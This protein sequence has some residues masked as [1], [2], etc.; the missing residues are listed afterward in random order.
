MIALAFEIL[1]S[2]VLITLAV[3]VVVTMLVSMI[4]SII[5]RILKIKNGDRKNEKS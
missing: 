1:I 4:S 5:I 3:V 2:S